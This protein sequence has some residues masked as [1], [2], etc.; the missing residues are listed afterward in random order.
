MQ[1]LV[2][3]RLFTP[4]LLISSATPLRAALSF[5]SGVMV[6]RS[7]NAK[8][9]NL[10]TTRYIPLSNQTTKKFMC[11]FR[12]ITFSNMKAFKI[13]YA[14]AVPNRSESDRYVATWIMPQR[15]IRETE[16]VMFAMA[17]LLPCFKIGLCGALRL[18]TYVRTGV[19]FLFDWY[20]KINED[21]I[22]W[23]R[24]WFSYLIDSRTAVNRRNV[25][26]ICFRT[27]VW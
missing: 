8:N 27:R 5:M 15:K 3:S 16:T 25:D 20:K 26:T 14:V 24:S 1:R 10:W 19:Y 12:S 22:Y 21:Q 7:C 23:M 11:S 2:S 13:S 17:L 6:W 18:K 9:G 4:P